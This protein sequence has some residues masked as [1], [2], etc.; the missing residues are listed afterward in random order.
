MAIGSLPPGYK[1]DQERTTGTSQ[2]ESSTFFANPTQAA[3][4]A[5]LIAGNAGR[6]S[7]QYFDFIENPT[8]HPLFQTTLQGMLQAL[9]PQVEQGYSDLSDMFRK[10]GV[11]TQQGGAYGVALG[12]YAGDVNRQQNELASK[13]LANMFPQVTQALDRPMSQVVPLLDATKLSRSASS[14]TQFSD[15]ANQALYR[16]GKINPN[17]AAMPFGFR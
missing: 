16:P 4:L 15:A 3:S 14:S 17:D 7:N 11:G 2:S 12:R 6:A 10:A 5:N 9:R 8:A 13:V 1:G